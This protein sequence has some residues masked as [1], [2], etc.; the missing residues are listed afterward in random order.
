MYYQSRRNQAVAWVQALRLL[1]DQYLFRSLVVEQ[2]ELFL[3][4]KKKP[5]GEAM[6]S[7]ERQ[8]S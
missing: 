4:Y 3:F 6:S 1:S 7:S 5:L 2:E 8:G